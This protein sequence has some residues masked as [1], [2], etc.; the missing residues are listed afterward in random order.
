MA[1][2]II[3]SILNTVIFALLKSSDIFV[4]SI[5]HSIGTITKLV[6]IAG[7]MII[8][9]KKNNCNYKLHDANDIL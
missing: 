5:S 8:L 2:L 4:Y 7:T 9:S 1:L 3:Q 6:W